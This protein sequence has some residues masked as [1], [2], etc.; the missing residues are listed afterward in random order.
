M[1]SA[2]ESRYRRLLVWQEAHKLVLFVYRET[3][4]WPSDERYSLISQTRRAAISIELNIAEG[5]SRFGAAEFARF[6]GI[7]IASL[8]ETECAMELA[9]ELEILPEDSLKKF[10]E[11]RSATAALLWRLQ[12]SLRRAARRRPSRVSH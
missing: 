7:A 9:N 1:P 10:R 6:V 2:G 5:A 11:H 8:A 4:R 12:A 3:Y